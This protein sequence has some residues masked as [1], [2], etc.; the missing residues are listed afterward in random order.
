MWRLYTVK[1]VQASWFIQESVL[2][3]YPKGQIRSAWEQEGQLRQV[4]RQ[5][6]MFQGGKTQTSALPSREER[7]FG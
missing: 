6:I 3:L 7:G 5:R 1:Y 2:R 4:E